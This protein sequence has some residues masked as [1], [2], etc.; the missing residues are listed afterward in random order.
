[1]QASCGVH[2]RTGDS[3]FW[4]SRA[5]WGCPIP[6]TLRGSQ[7]AT[8]YPADCTGQA[9]R[10][11][12]LAAFATLIFSRISAR[13]GQLPRCPGLLSPFPGS[14][15]LVAHS[16]RVPAPCARYAPV[17][18]TSVMVNSL[19]RAPALDASYGQ[20]TIVPWWQRGWRCLVPGPDRQ[21]RRGVLGWPAM[22]RTHPHGF[23]EE[24]VNANVNGTIIP[25]SSS[26]LP[27][28]PAVV[29]P[30]SSLPPVCV[31]GI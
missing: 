13:L 29:D 18:I 2:P 20:L 3:D 7:V 27:G 14:D 6:V 19:R 22:A 15:T 5:W 16:S 30:W 11:H 1:M 21:A 17:P 25:E 8:T 31:D 10:A 9:G 4:G 26:A 23:P 12:N 28:F 24:Q